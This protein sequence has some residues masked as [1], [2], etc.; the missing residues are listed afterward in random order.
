MT[1]LK[2][3]T[4]QLTFIESCLS[5]KKRGLSRMILEAVGAELA[6]SDDE[7]LAYLK[8]TFF[9]QQRPD[10]AA[11]C[12]KRD[13]RKSDIDQ[14]GVEWMQLEWILQQG[15]AALDFLVYNE[16]IRQL[17]EDERSFKFEVTHLGNAILKSGLSPEEGLLV[18]LDL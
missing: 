1:G 2:I 5:D 3:A 18:Y 9:W 13:K 15:K 10:R 4:Q 6:L 11:L 16:I 17:E 8:S 12:G 7:L 14:T